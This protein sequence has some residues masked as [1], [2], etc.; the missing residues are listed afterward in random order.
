[1]CEIFEKN[2][3]S[4]PPVGWNGRKKIKIKWFNFVQK[5]AKTSYDEMAFLPCGIAMSQDVMNCRKTEIDAI[6][7]AIVEQAKLYNVA[8]PYNRLIVD[9]IHAIE[10]SYKYQK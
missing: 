8:A 4:V 6:N 9:L 2:T 3:A 10:E 1:M 7:G 5:G